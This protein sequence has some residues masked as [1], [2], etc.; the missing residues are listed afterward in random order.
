MPFLSIHKLSGN[1][2]DLL[3]RKQAHM[4]PVVRRLAPEF[5][6]I[7]SITARLEDGL[8]TVNVWES[9]EGSLAFTQHPEVLQAQRDS[10][11]PQPTTFD[12]YTEV[13]YDDYS[14]MK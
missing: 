5:G 10:G 2:D 3:Q 4:D 12:R 7:I 11:L 6:A 1:P 8:L 13:Y 9:L 14:Q